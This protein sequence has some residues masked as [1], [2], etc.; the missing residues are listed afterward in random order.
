MDQKIKNKM[1][2]KDIKIEQ[3]KTWV[4]PMLEVLDQRKTHG[5][6]TPTWSEAEG[7]DFGAES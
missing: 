3:R 7:Y 6:T 2:N 1:D 5:G 4:R